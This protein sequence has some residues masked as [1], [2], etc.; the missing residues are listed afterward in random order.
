MAAFAAVF[1]GF[2]LLLDRTY[3]TLPLDRES[4][5]ARGARRRRPITL[6]NRDGITKD[7]L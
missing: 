1:V 4:R 7:D 3:G 2:I 5:F 6:F